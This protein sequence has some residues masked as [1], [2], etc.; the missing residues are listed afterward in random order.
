MTNNKQKYPITYTFH[1]VKDDKNN[2]YKKTI[3]NYFTKDSLDFFTENPKRVKMVTLG[4]NEKLIKEL[5]KYFEDRKKRKG[6][7]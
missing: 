2:Y 5:E 1:I 6:E 3:E 4:K 7:E